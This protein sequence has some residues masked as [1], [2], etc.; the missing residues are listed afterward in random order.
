MARVATVKRTCRWPWNWR[1]TCV[2]PST[3]AWVRRIERMCTKKRE[4]GTNPTV[5]GAVLCCHPRMW[6][7]QRRSRNLHAT[8]NVLCLFGRRAWCKAKEP[9]PRGDRIH[10]ESTRLL[11]ADAT[12]DGEVSRPSNTACSSTAA[13]LSLFSRLSFGRI[14]FVLRA[15]L[16]CRLS[17]CCSRA[18][19][20][21]CVPENAVCSEGSPLLLR[22]LFYFHTCTFHKVLPSSSLFPIV[23]MRNDANDSS[24]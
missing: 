1:R 15:T 7:N 14:T 9:S 4:D 6:R 8:S 12:H 10:F 24:S 2:V 20:G 17:T 3:S 19:V 16:K 18:Q 13:T 5:R 22:S 11:R 23:G 21:W